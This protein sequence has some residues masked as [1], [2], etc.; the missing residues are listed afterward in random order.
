MGVAFL[1]VASQQIA[2]CHRGHQAEDGSESVSKMNQRKE[3]RGEKK[4][5][6]LADRRFF[7]C[8]GGEQQVKEKIEQTE[9]KQEKNLKLHLALNSF[10]LV[11]FL[12]YQILI[13]FKI[14]IIYNLM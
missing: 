13:I 14:L 6:Q 10:R 3:E 7:C 11:N 12:K 9:K 8:L 2:L 4:D 5:G 1:H